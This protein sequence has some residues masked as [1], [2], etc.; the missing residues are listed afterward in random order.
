MT[1]RRTRQYFPCGR[2]G[3]WLLL[4]LTC[5]PSFS[6]SPNAGAAAAEPVP[7]TSQ[8]QAARDPTP[9]GVPLPALGSGMDAV[10][11]RAVTD[12]WMID[13]RETWERSQPERL[14]A[15]K[16]AVRKANEQ[17]QPEQTE[18]AVDLDRDG[19]PDWWV[20]FAADRPLAVE[21]DRYQI[22]VRDRRIDLDKDPGAMTD[23]YGWFVEPPATVPRKLPS[24]AV[25]ELFDWAQRSPDAQ[26]LSGRYTRLAEQLGLSPAEPLQKLAAQPPEG[27]LLKTLE[28]YVRQTLDLAARVATLP[29]EKEEPKGRKGRLQSRTFEP[30]DLDGRAGAELAVCRQD[31]RIVRVQFYARDW[32]DAE[33]YQA[34][35]ILDRDQIESLDVGGR[36]FVPLCG[37]WARVHPEA[38]RRLAETYLLPGFRRYGLGD[39]YAAVAHWRRGTQLAALLGDFPY[40]DRGEPAGEPVR[41]MRGRGPRSALDGWDFEVEELPAALLLKLAWNFGWQKSFDMVATLHDL[42]EHRQRRHDDRQAL[43]LYQLAFR[44]ADKLHDP[45]GQVNSLDWMSDIHRRLGQYDTAVEQLFRSLDLESS[46]AYAMDMAQGLEDLCEDPTDPF[47]I[48]RVKLVRTHAMAVNRACKLASIAALYAHLGDQL[49]AEGYLQEAERLFASLGHRYGQADL[50]TLRASWDLHAGRGQLALDRLKRAQ[51]L[52]QQQ[53]ADQ[54][55]AKRGRELLSRGAAWHHFQVP[56]DPVYLTIDMRS[57]SNPLSYLALTEG[58]MAEACLQQAHQTQDAKQRQTR[59]ELAAALQQTALEKYLQTKDWA[60][61]LQSRLRLATILAALGD[62]DQVLSLSGEVGKAAQEHQ[63]PELH[64][65]SLALQAAVRQAQGRNA[66]AIGLYEGAAAEIESLRSGLRSERI[67]RGFFSTRQDV[68]EQ[69]TLLYLAGCEAAQGA[70]AEA[71]KVWRCLER[72]KARSLLD[73]LGGRP[74]EIKGEEVVQAQQNFPLAFSSFRA[75]AVW[76]APSADQLRAREDVLRQIAATPAYQEVASLS[77]VQPADLARVRRLLEDDDLLVEYGVLHSAVIAV[78]ISPRDIRALR[79]TAGGR[80]ELQRKV[81]EFRQLV[82]NPAADVRDAGRKLYDQLLAPCLAGRDGVRHVCVVPGEML[83]YLPFDALMLPDGRFAAERCLLTY[84]PSASALVYACERRQAAPS[85]KGAQTLVVADPRARLDYGALSGAAIEGQRIYQLAP[86]PKLLLQEDQATETALVRQLPRSRYFHFAGHT[87]FS[88]TFP[89]RTALLCTEDVDRDG[90]L[91]V[92][93][94]FELNLPFCE[95][96]VL[97]ACQTRLGRWSSGDEIVGLERAFLRAGVPSVVASLW[98]VDDAATSLLMETF[99][100]QLWRQERPCGQALQQAKLALLRSPQDLRQRRKALEEKLAQ[101][102]E[103]EQLL[104]TRGVRLDDVRELPAAEASSDSTRTHPA[105]WA[106]FTLSG[107]WR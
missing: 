72:S 34:E 40:N 43:E 23:A 87:Q 76:A 10:L 53:L 101:R 81:S 68:Y 66:D 19:Q 3:A 80:D 74:L 83:H 18:V 6:G 29:L 91:E 4:A 69:L 32:L 20:F 65:R 71:E 27:D 41:S 105:F 9:A 64:W 12:P 46:L 96:A 73:I 70:E 49:Q 85:A 38:R 58:L 56:G 94:L 54:Q 104:D 44:V 2:I 75:A 67:R 79:L 63:I 82:Q 39:W 51:S 14:A 62:L 36:A 11:R 24:L 97:S 35:A 98:K 88:E 42:A 92:E 107:Q 60:G 48:Q 52:L 5:S 25:V 102:G 100:D 8:P 84:A 86:E 50:L 17:R 77:T 93:E 33:G 15:V 26:R 99:Y 61:I 22:G 13:R 95:L 16:Q 21:G 57:P 30:L 55:A 28:A 78:V 37:C 7:A 106:A 59:L 45:S 103:I 47:E 89:L 90:R 1:G 31:G